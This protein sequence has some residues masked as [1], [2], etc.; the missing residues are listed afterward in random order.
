MSR[1]DK[2]SHQMELA[3]KKID[4]INNTINK[5]FFN[6]YK[7]SMTETIQKLNMFLNQYTALIQKISNQRGKNVKPEDIKLENLTNDEK[8]EIYKV[9][10][11]ATIR[12]ITMYANNF[13]N[14]VE[15]L[16]D[17]A[18]TSIP[19]KIEQMEY[20]NE[21]ISV[22]SSSMSLILADLKNRMIA[23]E[24]TA[25][26]L[27]QK[28]A[29]LGVAPADKDIKKAFRERTKKIN[30]VYLKYTHSM[31]AGF[32][33]LYDQKHK[34]GYLFSPCYTLIPKNVEPFYICREG[35][36]DPKHFAGIA[37]RLKSL[38]DEKKIKYNFYQSNNIFNFKVILDKVLLE[39]NTPL[40]NHISDYINYFAG[41][42]KDSNKEKLQSALRNKI[43]INIDSIE[44]KPE[45]GE[46]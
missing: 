38:F 9:L 42:N 30:D 41:I 40:F 29:M 12:E 26:E 44:F 43:T 6:V 45:Q 24:I 20:N 23:S 17:T 36:Q 28:S 31:P 27:A 32:I 10:N 5:R 11:E 21:K 39:Q 13:A 34:K 46:I 19:S 15:E 25:F 22:L 2:L 1:L 8:T 4:E 18:M 37:G 3:L 14:I 33:S 35:I 7:I 16:F